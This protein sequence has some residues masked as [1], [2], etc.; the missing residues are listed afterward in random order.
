MGMIASAKKE[1]APDMNRWHADIKPDNILIVH[2]KFKLADFGFSRFAPVVKGSDGTLPTEVIT[3]FTDT[4][5]TCYSEYKMTLLLKSISGAPEVSRMIG[6][7]GTLSGVRQSIDTW[8]FGCVLSVAATWIVLGFPGVL[9]YQKLRTLAPSNRQDEKT[10]DRFH[11]GMDVLPEIRKWHNYLRGRIR[12]SD[13][14]TPLV[15]NLIEN[16]MLQADASNRHEIGELCEELRDLIARATE[17]IKSLGVHSRDTDPLVSAALL[18]LEQEAQEERSSRPRS[19]PLQQQTNV[20]GDATTNHQPQKTSR[21]LEKDQLPKSK[22]LGQTT[23]RKEILEHQLQSSCIKENDE[24]LIKELHNGAITNS[25][26]QSPSL[27]QV[28]AKRQAK[29][30]NPDHHVP[31][32]SLHDSKSIQTNQA[33]QRYPEVPHHTTNGYQQYPGTNEKAPVMTQSGAPQSLESPMIQTESSSALH[34]V[35]RLWPEAP[36]NKS[37]TGWPPSLPLGGSSTFTNAG[38]GLKSSSASPRND[39]I[40]HMPPNRAQSWNPSPSA[41]MYPIQPRV[42]GQRLII[43]NNGY[44]PQ[45]DWIDTSHQLQHDYESPIS[46]SILVTQPLDSNSISTAE[47]PDLPVQNSYEGLHSMEKQAVDDYDGYGGS[48]LARYDPLPSTVLELRYDI[49]Q[50]RM[51][52]EQDTTKSLKAR[53]KGKLGF[54]DRKKDSNLASTFENR[55][56]LVGNPSCSC[57]YLAYLS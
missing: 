40:R 51:I 7:D 48:N 46:P 54:E 11:N 28:E 33:R 16:N 12:P 8:S 9:Q 35:R 30:R 43:P 3:G 44:L 34:G 26:T 55:R 53:F 17:K 18:K 39:S 14:T 31:N 29:P 20:V 21:Y 38:L 5:G 56:D 6:S 47:R 15:L 24:L 57:L 41:N 27:D 52:L 2:G 42:S 22:P 45:G 1:M 25:P 32:I 50:K 10:Y 23:Y 49:C 36:I 4:Y 37:Q 13:T 19:T